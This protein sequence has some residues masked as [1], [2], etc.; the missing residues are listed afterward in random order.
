MPAIFGLPHVAIVLTRT[1]QPSLASSI[2]TISR[3]SLSGAPHTYF[4]R[5][6]TVQGLPL[7]QDADDIVQETV[8]R[9]QRASDV[10]IYAWFWSA[11]GMDIIIRHTD[12]LLEADDVLL[13]R[14]KTWRPRTH[15]SAERLRQRLATIG[16]VMQP[17]LAEV[18]RQANKRS[19]NRGSLWVPRFRT[20]LLADDA[21][22]LTSLA[23]L[24]H[25]FS[26]AQPAQQKPLTIAMHNPPMLPVRRLV[27]GQCVP[28]DQA[29]FGDAPAH[30]A[31]SR[32]WFD[33]F[34]SDL[35]S[36]DFNAYAQGLQ[37]ALALGRPE[38]LTESLSR[39]S[40]EG[41]RGR[42]RQAHD[43][44]DSWGICGIWG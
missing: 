22:L 36:E 6:R 27:S 40:R 18:S 43:L 12:Q 21:A 42:N 31:T 9:W 33:E 23:A 34:I 25:R 14:W 2:M 24:E 17:L 32:Q 30:A 35:S 37:R 41:G 4:M 26:T 44:Y 16:G 11:C 8:A 5:A 20:C 7:L 29:M 28:A 19:G 39:L 13:A 10:Q 1:F 38:S 3:Q 15:M